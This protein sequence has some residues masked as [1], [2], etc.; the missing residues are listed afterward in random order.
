MRAPAQCRCRHPKHP[1][2][3]QP[4]PRKIFHFTEI[5]KWRMYPPSRLILEGR[6]R[7]VLIASRVCGGRGRRWAREVRAGRV[8]PVSPKPRADERRCQVRLA[9]GFSGMSTRP[10]KTAAKQRAVRTAKPCGPGRRRY[11]QAFAE[12]RGAQPGEAHHQFAKRGR[13]EGIRLPGEHGISRQ[14]I[15]QGRPSVRHHLYAAVRFFLRYI[16]AQRT[17]GARSAPGLPCALS[18]KRAER[19]IKARAESA[20]RTRSHVR[21]SLTLNRGC[22]FWIRMIA[23]C[24]DRMP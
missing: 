13:P 7:V 23:S 24:F 22:G 15:A 12:V 4:L 19:R 6:S 14:T 5:R 9:C 17:A 16:F 3:R 10:G 20:A 1:A 8:V 18:D 11:G 2:P 21:F